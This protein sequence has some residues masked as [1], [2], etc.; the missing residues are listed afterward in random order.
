MGTAVRTYNGTSDGLNS[1]RHSRH[2]N[3]FPP[4]RILGRDATFCTA[5]DAA[6]DLHD[7]TILPHIPLVLW[8]HIQISISVLK[9]MLYSHKPDDDLLSRLAF[10]QAY[11]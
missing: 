9:C 5:H 7:K 8:P 4:I 3:R 1:G 2:R 10:M 6:R 11:Y